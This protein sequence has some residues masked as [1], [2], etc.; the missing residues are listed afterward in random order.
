MSKEADVNKIGSW[1]IEN[2]DK[3][4]KE[5]SGGNYKRM[6]TLMGYTQIESIKRKNKKMYSNRLRRDGII[7]SVSNFIPNP[8]LDNSDLDEEIVEIL[9]YVNDKYG[10]L[11]SEGI[12]KVHLKLLNMFDDPGELKKDLDF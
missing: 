6:L 2:N 11:D 8:G 4:K 9:D 1:Y 5:V 12:D 3:L 10:K 7:I